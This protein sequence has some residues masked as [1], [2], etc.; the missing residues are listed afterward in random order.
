MYELT[1]QIQLFSSSGK[2]SKPKSNQ[3]N[4]LNKQNPLQNTNQP[5]HNT[6]NQ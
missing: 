2:K 4:Q 1:L 6:S 3:T 5:T